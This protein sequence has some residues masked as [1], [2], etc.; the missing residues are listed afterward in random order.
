MQ[1]VGALMDGANLR[2]LGLYVF[3]RMS[4]TS[5]RE[6]PDEPMDVYRDYGAA[7]SRQLYRVLVIANPFAMSGTARYKLADLART[8]DNATQAQP[9]LISWRMAMTSAPG[10]AQTI[11]AEGVEAGYNLLVA[12]G[13]DGTV[14]EVVNGMLGSGLHLGIIPFGTVNNFARSLGCCQPL[15]DAVRTLFQGRRIQQGVCAVNDRYFI[16]SIQIGPD[17]CQV[18]RLRRGNQKG[19]ISLIK[20]MR[21]MREATEQPDTIPISVV[22]ET[23]ARQAE[24]R[25]LTVRIGPDPA[26]PKSARMDTT[27]HDRMFCMTES[28]FGNSADLKKIVA[29]VMQGRCKIPVDET[30]GHTIADVSIALQAPAVVRIDGD[31]CQLSRVNVANR[32]DK[33]TVLVP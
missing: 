6:T 10:D 23:G 17:P 9:N 5:K 11:A 33:I 16:D 27:E 15:K 20:V 24:I 1:P 7:V 13:G 14:S 2:L 8:M 30:V 28:D 12:A 18:C 25:S 21:R 4:D 31:L 19:K 26:C 32:G 3:M 29:D 22:D